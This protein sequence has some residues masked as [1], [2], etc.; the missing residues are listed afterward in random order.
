MKATIEFNLEDQEDRMSHERCTMSFELAM[1]LYM[2]DGY[3]RTQLKYNEDGLTPEAYQA[4]EDA[5]QRL[6]DIM[7]DNGIMLDR[8][9]G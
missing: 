6:K 3:L 5:R 2:F 1:S 4:L 9:I 8:L 7:N